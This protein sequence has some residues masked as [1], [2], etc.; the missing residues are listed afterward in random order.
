MK[1][2]YYKII[3]IVLMALSIL[4]TEVTAQTQNT[5]EVGGG[6]ITI[7][8]KITHL[9]ADFQDCDGSNGDTDYR[10][11]VRFKYGDLTYSD[12]CVQKD[13][14]NC[15]DEDWVDVNS[16]NLML[17]DGHVTENTWPLHITAIGQSDIFPIESY[18]C[19]EDNGIFG[20]C[21]SDYSQFT[22][23]DANICALTED[24]FDLQQ[25]LCFVPP[26]SGLGPEGRFFEF[27]YTCPINNNFLFSTV[28]SGARVS[29]NYTPPA[30]KSVSGPDN[31]CANTFAPVYVGKSACREQ[32]GA[33]WNELYDIYVETAPGS[34]QFEM[35][36]DNCS[37]GGSHFFP[38][39]GTY[40]LRAYTVAANDVNVRSENYASGSVTITPEGPVAIVCPADT[41]LYSPRGVIKPPPGAP[42]FPYVDSDCWARIDFERERI[43]E[44]SSQGYTE[45][46]TYHAVDAAGN[47]LASCVQYIEVIDTIPPYVDEFFTCGDAPWIFDGTGTESITA[48][49]AAYDYAPVVDSVHFWDY[50]YCVSEFEWAYYYDVVTDDGCTDGVLNVERHWS[51]DDGCGNVLLGACVEDIQVNLI[52]GSVNAELDNT[53]QDLEG[54]GQSAINVANT[55]FDFSTT[56]SSVAAADFPGTITTCT[57]A[58]PT[59]AYIDVI[60]DD[61]CP[62]PNF[63]V[64]RTWTVTDD[65]NNTSV[66][67]QTFSVVD[68]V[69]V[70]ATCNGDIGPLAGCDETVINAATT[71]FDF[72]T[73]V[74]SITLADFPGTISDLGGACAAT[75]ATYID[76]IEQSSCPN[77]V[78]TVLR[79]WTISNA[80]G[81]TSTCTQTISVQDMTVPALDNGNANDTTI[82]CTESTAPTATG[83]P[84]VADNCSATDAIS[85]QFSDVSTQ[86]STAC[87]QYNYQI[88]R[89][90]MATDAC[91]NTATY[92]QIIT[93]EDTTPPMLDIAN[94]TDQTL[95]CGSSTLPVATGMLA[96]TDACASTDEMTITHSD[97]STQGSDACSTYAY[98]IMRTWT[99]SDACGNTAVHTQIIKLTDDI[100]PVMD[101]TDIP[102]VRIECDQSSD[103]TAVGAPVAMDNCSTID[104]I[105]FTFSDVSTQGLS[106][107]SQYEYTILRTW[108]AADAC[109][110]TS[111]CSQSIQVEDTTPPVADCTQVNNVNISCE[112]STDP[113][114]TGM[115][116]VS[117]NCAVEA[118]ISTTFTDQSTQ[119]LFG[120]SQYNYT[121]TRNWLT[122]DVCGNSSTCIQT[123]LV[124]DNTP[125]SITAPGEINGLA[126]LTDPPVGVTSINAFLNL[127]GATAMDNCASTNELS[128]SFVDQPVHPALLDYCSAA[129]AARTITRTYTITDVCGNSSTASQA[130]IYNQSANGPSVSAPAGGMI[131]CSYNAVPNENAAQVSTDCI[132]GYDLS[133]DGPFV[134]GAVNCPG[135][136]YTYTYTVEDACGRIAT[137]QQV[138]TVENEGPEFVCPPDI[139]VIDCPADTDMIQASFANFAST[140]VV[141]TSCIGD[142]SILNDFSPDGF[143][144]QDCNGGVGVAIPNTVAYQIVTFTAT[145]Q[146][147]R[148]STCTALVVIKDSTAPSISGE[149]YDAIRYHNALSQM[150][151]D[152]WALDNIA[153]M[154]A[155]DECNSFVE[156]PEW[157]YAPASP[158][159]AFS[160]PFATTVVTFT[161]SDQCGNQ[162]STTATFRLKA[163]PISPLASVSGAIFT[164]ALAEVENVSVSIHQDGLGV[165]DEEMTNEGGGFDFEMETQQNYEL[166][167]YRNDDPLNGV[168]TL[169][170]IYIS[171]HILGM[172]ALNSPY[173]MIAADVNNSGSITAA[174]LV[175]LRK[176][177]LFIDEE[178]NNNT[179]WRFVAES[180]AFFDPLNPFTSTFPEVYL[181]NGLTGDQMANFI[182]IKVGDVNGSATP[183]QFLAGDTRDA[184]QTLAFEMEDQWLEAGQVY[185]VPVRAKDFKAMMGYQ[186]SWRID[187]DRVE[188]FEVVPGELKHLSAENFGQPHRGILTGSWN[189]WPALDMSAE[190]TLFSLQLKTKQAARL[191][192]VLSAAPGYTPAEAYREDG[193]V[194]DL[195]LVFREGEKPNSNSFVLHQNQ[196]NPFDD[197]TIIGFEI[198]EAGPVR[199][200]LYDVTGKILQQVDRDLTRGYHQITID[201]ATLGEKGLLYYRLSAAGQS[202]T[203]K[204]IRF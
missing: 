98:T 18:G 181:L 25:K 182:A 201:G 183:N 107:C 90:W 8:M 84:G 185:T 167:P 127:N 136:T 159:T 73:T 161:A 176:L 170:L 120:C 17:L 89:T 54:C 114:N 142:L 180:H 24:V 35:I 46:N 152:N 117:D 145:D 19:W 119:G 146:C 199:L 134:D 101:C 58:N 105:S 157:T 184:V 162:A 204:M 62:S 33:F 45:V 143:I 68:N 4:N 39:P 149:T 154:T 173:E 197:Q 88:T 85:L 126:C 74:A 95:A 139:C 43:D 31:A 28:T 200:V 92:D 11:K 144:P 20:T 131:N 29:V 177:I 129:P 21:N 189:G 115:L 163:E 132:L 38:D 48:A 151:Y 10:W 23:Y 61:A 30:P 34:G 121:I 9:G 53:S 153:S 82:D 49:N 93:V 123:I 169:D 41:T 130:L 63:V 156:S 118:D 59:V 81:S 122:T 165:I 80:C 140:A 106:G 172:Q 179:S 196:P 36:C 5:T 168:N 128:V 202:A 64:E 171:Q 67:T 193:E 137:D 60:I 7:D 86:G 188:H 124:S 100:A 70:S 75:S 55:G 96:A 109:G 22:S 77:P 138:F 16:E 116:L 97:Q 76:V 56:S 104:D 102:S 175:E 94:V 166:I 174:D 69:G 99:A 133:V 141:S 148:S 72:S 111:T 194:M 113:T 147:Q 1:V 57:S 42:I 190:R 2:Q 110:N 195:A 203:K 65:G 51:F 83:E 13:C 158:N 15:N 44:C 192:E 198:P 12:D 27:E 187:Q 186:F 6:P 125:P 78:L 112:E 40:Q 91:G 87:E 155:E 14:C 52:G 164:E 160:G 26:L 79:T 103:P 66:T 135:T 150:E 3:S 37:G 50:I 32:F 191:S 178:L 108:T 71:G 47:I